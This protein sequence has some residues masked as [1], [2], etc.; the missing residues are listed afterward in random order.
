[1]E[2]FQENCEIWR[3]EKGITIM[4]IYDFLMNEDSLDM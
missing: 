2:L 1:M 4:G 3:N